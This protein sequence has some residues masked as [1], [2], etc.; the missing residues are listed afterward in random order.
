MIEKTVLEIGK[1]AVNTVEWKD[2]E[3]DKEMS[4]DWIEKQSYGDIPFHHASTDI[5]KGDAVKLIEVLKTHF[6][7]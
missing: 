2:G 7:I 6:D 3:Y 1:I 5:T 4:F